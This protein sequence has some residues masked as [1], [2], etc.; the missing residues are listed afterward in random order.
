MTDAKFSIL[1]IAI[2]FLGLLA[3]L[4]L[5]ALVR[6]SI[7]IRQNPT[8]FDFRERSGH[9]RFDIKFPD[10]SAF[11]RCGILHV[12]DITKTSCW[13][14]TEADRA[15]EAIAERLVKP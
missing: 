13:W 7:A 6:D 15:N 2:V 4:T 10:K 14:V 11:L 12:E 5:T 1:S 3:L 9:T 8:V